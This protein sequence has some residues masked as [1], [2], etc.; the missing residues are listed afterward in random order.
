M[1]EPLVK[2]SNIKWLYIT[3]ITQLKDYEE[4]WENSIGYSSESFFSSP[5]WIG[6]WINTFWTKNHS[7]HLY[8]VLDN[9]KCVLFAPF[10]IQRQASFPFI[11]ILTLLGQGESEIY[12]VSSEYQ[13][14]LL[15]SHY[16]FL[17]SDLTKRV[18]NLNFD[19]A[20]INS[21]LKDANILTLFKPLKSSVIQ[22]SGIRYTY[23]PEVTST[24]KLSKNNKSKLNK[25]INKLNLLR[26]QYV[27]VEEENYDNYWELM[28]EF[29]QIRWRNKNK[30]GAFFHA[31]F[32]QFHKKFRNENISNIKIS[33]VIAD[34]RPI[35][36]NYYYYSNKTLYFYQSGWDETNYAKVS[37]GFALHI[38]SMKNSDGA[39]YD[40][41]KGDATNSYKA[42]LGCNHN[43][44]MYNITLKKSKY[45][46]ILS[47][48]IKK[49]KTS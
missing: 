7:L 22:Q 19:H 48:F 33:A 38:W 2:K 10:Y 12:E 36:I 27:W 44:E 29:H 14:I 8:I 15:A 35:A 46:I 49:L 41:M 47:K 11:R 5:K 21:L 30:K 23:S 16:K 43:S 42:K 20:N 28:K 32:S 39:L 6:N 13:D 9:E 45:K 31:K 4:L 1:I 25:A 26:A 37:P 24:P 40:F 34:N 18:I 17:L 3:D